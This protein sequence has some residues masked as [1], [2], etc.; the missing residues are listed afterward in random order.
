MLYSLMPPVLVILSLIGIIIFLLKKSARVASIPEDGGEL[1]NKE[2]EAE[3]KKDSRWKHN[4][5][6]IA[7]GIIRMFRSVFLKLGAKFNEWSQ[8]IRDKRRFRVAANKSN[9]RETDIIEKIKEYKIEKEERKAVAHGPQKSLKPV[10]SD[11]VTAPAAKKEIKDRLEDLLI[12]R[13][14]ANPRDIEAY[15]RL[16]EY[17]MEIESYVDAKECFRQI[18]KLDPKNRSIKYKLRKLETLIK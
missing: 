12:D 5:L 1:L 16:G 18:V 3:P 15:E 14:A 10:I 17:Y 11:R 13:I 2:S 4:F 6:G 7:E 8:V 9:D